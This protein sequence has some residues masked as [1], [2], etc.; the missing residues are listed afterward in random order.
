MTLRRAVG[1]YPGR[2]RKILPSIKIST[3][4]GGSG[5]LLRRIEAE[6]AKPQGDI[7]WSSGA[8][9]LGAFKTLYE[10]YKPAG[11]DKILAS[12][13][14]PADLWSACNIHVAV[15]MVNKNQLG[16]AAMPA[17]WS[18][19]SDS[20]WK[21]KLIIADPANS[22]TGYTILWGLEKMLGATGFAA[23]AKN[24]KVTS[25]APTVLRG[26]AQGEYAMGLTFEANAYTYVAGGQSEIALVYP[27]EGTFTTAEYL[28]LIKARRRAMPPRGSPIFWSR[29]R[30]RLRCWSPPSVARPGPTSR[31]ANMS[32]CRSSQTSRCLQ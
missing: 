5:Q 16:G 18:D 24:L 26:V 3:V 22:S 15:L 29:A 13:R 14:D 7:F 25:S 28:T 8:N 11:S 27:T 6:A 2:H 32:S 21:G 9:T 23:L 1:R 12:L 20:R 17:T 31:S 4:T 30:C 10:P 19:L